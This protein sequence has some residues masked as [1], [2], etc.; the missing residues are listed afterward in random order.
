MFPS[1][2]LQIIE[3]VIIA[4]QKLLDRSIPEKSIKLIIWA[5][6]LGA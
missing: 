2:G 3:P 6:Y 1:F 4:L 5:G